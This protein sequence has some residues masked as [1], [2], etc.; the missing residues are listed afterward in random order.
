M[1]NRQRENSPG[2]QAVQGT[3]TTWGWWLVKMRAL[4][5]MCVCVI[6]VQLYIYFSTSGPSAVARNGA[7]LANFIYVN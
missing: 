4:C 2:M 6:H 5:Y 1:R 3:G 7:I